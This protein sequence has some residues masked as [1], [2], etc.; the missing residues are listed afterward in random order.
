M[1]KILGSI[2]ILACLVITWRLF[3]TP[4]GIDTQTHAA[5]QS[6]LA[7]LIED[8]IKNKRPAFSDFKL[9]RLTTQ[10]INQDLIS[11][12]F[13]YKYSDILENNEEGDGQA[14]VTQS[15]TG[16]ALLARSPSENA[17]IQRWVIQNINTNRESVSFEEGLVIVSG[18]DDALTTDS[19]GLESTK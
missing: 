17:S 14:T 11:A 7:I 2:I 12:Q 8:T 16:N 18:P 19:K 5:I 10:T 15:I 9:E 1:R 13:S 4:S 3:N 6:Q